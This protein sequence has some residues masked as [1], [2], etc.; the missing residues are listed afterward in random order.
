MFAVD[1]D[2]TATLFLE[3]T[4]RSSLLAIRDRNSALNVLG[5]SR[6]WNSLK[7]SQVSRCSLDVVRGI[8]TVVQLRVTKSW[9]TQSLLGASPIGV[10]NIR[11]KDSTDGFGPF[12]FAHKVRRAFQVNLSVAV[13]IGTNVGFDLSNSVGCGSHRKTWPKEEGNA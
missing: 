6:E 11:K 9:A 12:K 4:H 1:I 2:P 8:I 7:R 3:D 5:S 10:A 13:G